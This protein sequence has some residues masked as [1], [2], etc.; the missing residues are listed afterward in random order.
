MSCLLNRNYLSS[1]LIL[2]KNNIYR[3]LSLSLKWHGMFC[4]AKRTSLSINLWCAHLSHRWELRKKSHHLCELYNFEIEISL[5][6]IVIYGIAEKIQIMNV[7]HPLPEHRWQERD[8]CVDFLPPA[9]LRTTNR[10]R[11]SREQPQH[12]LDEGKAHRWEPRCSH[13]KLCIDRGKN[14]SNWNC[15]CSQR[16]CTMCC[17]PTISA[18]R[19][20]ISFSI[21]QRK[22]Q[23]RMTDS[24]DFRLLKWTEGLNKMSSTAEVDVVY[25]ITLGNCQTTAAD[26]SKSTFQE[27]ETSFNLLEIGVRILTDVISMRLLEATLLSSLKSHRWHFLTFC[28]TLFRLQKMFHLL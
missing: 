12:R 11:S 3:V 10:W 26:R 18:V 20:G 22:Q 6:L 8:L 24:N 17:D 28:R 2:D 27:M 13:T 14:P 25:I 7:K 4:I 15:Y 5:C 23:T 19:K 16:C 21:I 1:L 9:S